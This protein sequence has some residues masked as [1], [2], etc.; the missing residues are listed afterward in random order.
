MLHERRRQ[1]HGPRLVV[2]RGE[3]GDDGRRVVDAAVG[4][5]DGAAARVLRVV[6][7]VRLA[8]RVDAR[9]RRVADG[10]E[11]AQQPAPRRG[12]V[13]DARHDVE[14]LA[15]PRELLLQDR[16]EE[17]VVLLA[18]RLVARDQGARLAAARRRV[19]QLRRV[20][21]TRERRAQRPRDG[22]RRQREHVDVDAGGLQP[23]LLPHAEPLLLVDDGEA[24]RVPDLL[25][26][27]E[28]VRA[29]ADA[30]PARGDLLAHA[31]AL[32]GRRRALARGLVDVLPARRPQELDRDAQGLQAP[33]E[34]LVV[35]L[36]EH[37]RRREDGDLAPALDRERGRADREL[38]LPE[39]DLYTCEI[40][41]PT[42][43]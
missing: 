34:D 30:A 23:L 41:N 14:A 25:R 21:Q 42:S 40:F 22:R 11:R 4:D 38:R 36:G 17:V 35:L 6:V 7:V 37:G 19:R 26:R 15:A 12:H 31:A 33:P 2:A 28:R 13:G 5:G 24:Q 8:G 3:V 20:P 1:E 10:L 32:L 43:M 27:Q 9:G 39:A 16:R 18:A 29:D